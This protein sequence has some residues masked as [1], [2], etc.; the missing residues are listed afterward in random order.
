MAK[1]TNQTSTV[2]KPATGQTGVQKGIVLPDPG[3]DEQQ[4][5]KERKSTRFCTLLLMTDHSW[6]FA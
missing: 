2:S 4:D 6:S 3:K 5:L 1:S